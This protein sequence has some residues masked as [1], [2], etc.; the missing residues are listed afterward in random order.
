MGKMLIIKGASFTP[1]TSGG[2]D[3]NNNP[4]PQPPVQMTIYKFYYLS[5]GTWYLNRSAASAITA[6]GMVIADYADASITRIDTDLQAIPAPLCVA[7]FGAEG[8]SLGGVSFA[9]PQQSQW[10]T[11]VNM[12]AS[13]DVT[14]V[15][16]SPCALLWLGRYP[17][18]VLTS[19]EVDAIVAAAPSAITFN[20]G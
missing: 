2:G 17:D 5:G 14:Q 8:L 13:L 10:A 1:S 6:V 20:H 4:V 18:T 16:G 11:A 15:M 7:F 12:S 9:D 19:E 3:Q